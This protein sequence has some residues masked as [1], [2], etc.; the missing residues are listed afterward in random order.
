VETLRDLRAQL[1][2]AYRI[3]IDAQPKRRKRPVV[4]TAQWACGCSAAGTHLRSLV[5][6]P[7]VAHGTAADRSRARFGAIPVLGGL[8]TRS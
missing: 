8:L 2:R 7:C 4:I 5:R 3:Q 1:G 6:T